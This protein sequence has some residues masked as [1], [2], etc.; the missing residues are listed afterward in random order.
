METNLFGLILSSGWEQVGRENR[1]GDGEWKNVLPITPLFHEVWVSMSF[2]GKVWFNQKICKG[3]FREW[4]LC[5][6]SLSSLI[7]F[8]SN[9]TPP[10][11]LST[12]RATLGSFGKMEETLSQH[13]A[14]WLP[15]TYW[16]SSQK[17][18]WKWQLHIGYLA[19][20]SFKKS[21]MF[22]GFYFS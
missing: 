1:D 21:N 11:F 15:S 22:N 8:L 20:Y 4:K 9:L 17:R 2:G 10:L 7:L 19:S 13:K 12:I 3:K 6:E 16:H 5:K 18:N 14:R